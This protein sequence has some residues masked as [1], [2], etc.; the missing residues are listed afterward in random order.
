[1]PIN[2]LP[3]NLVALA[4]LTALAVADWR[5]RHVPQVVTLPALAVIAI[6]RLWHG[7]VNVWVYWLGAFLL[8][9]AHIYGAGDAKVLMIELGLWPTTTF[10]SVLGLTVAVLGGIVLAARFRSTRIVAYTLR[11]A[12]Q[13]L[14]TG[15]FPYKSELELYGAPQVYLY[16]AGAAV[17]LAM[18]LAG[19]RL[20]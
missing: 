2:S 12:G 15:Q 14:L 8:Y 9:A 16:V 19:P 11:W 3:L 1:M 20:W 5:T 13:R 18:S 7:D 10:V 17:Y 6:W 4:I